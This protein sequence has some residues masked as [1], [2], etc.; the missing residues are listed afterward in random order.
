VVDLNKQINYWSKGA[1]DDIET[2]KILINRN[3]TLQGLFFCHLS[4][5]K[6]LKAIF[7]KINNDFAPKTHN[8]MYLLEK[9]NINFEENDEEF[10]GI[11]MKYQLQGR[12]PDYN[13]YLPDKKI[14]EEYLLKTE[15]LLKWLKEKL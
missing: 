11:L 10:L 1:D 12:Y 8:L 3:K 13:P 15:N 5:E 9:S 6:I 14:M 4:I 7:V 2:A